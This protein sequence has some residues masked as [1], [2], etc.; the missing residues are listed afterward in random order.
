[1]S[2]LFVWDAQRM[3]L[4]VSAMDDEH[5]K[6]IELM[7]A[8]HDCN[9]KGA[10]KQRL[11]D[12]LSELCAF[13]IVHFQH[14]EAYLESIHFTGLANH[15]GIH[16]R[17][18]S[19]LKQHKADYESSTSEKINHKFFDFLTLWLS[20]HIQHVDMQYSPSRLQQAG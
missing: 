2:G 8:L 4:K 1:M 17:L 18:L 12:L 11:L 14:E 10:T 15:K 7:N 9:K 19:Q 16:Q 5:K 13:V 20:A 3:E 6:L